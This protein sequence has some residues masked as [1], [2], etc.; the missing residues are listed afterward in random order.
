MK[1][2]GSLESGSRSIPGTST[3]RDSPALKTIKSSQSGWRTAT[4]RRAIDAVVSAGRPAGAFLR[5]YG[6]SIWPHAR[7]VFAAVSEEWA[8]EIPPEGD[9]V[10]ATNPQYRLTAEG[11]LRLLPD[12]RQV[13]LIAGSTD[14][15]RRWLQAARADL[16][17]LDRRLAVHELA[18]LTWD[19]VLERV[20]T[21]P[22]DSVA[23][24]VAFFA[25]ATG[26]TFV[27]RD[28]YVDLAAAANRPMFAT[29]STFAGAGL[30]GGL[31]IDYRLVG[32]RAA[33]AAA[34]ELTGR[35]RLASNVVEA[36]ESRWMF[37]GRQLARWGIRESRL[38]A[39]SEVLFREPSFFQRNKNLALGILAVVALQA[40]IIGMLLIERRVRRRTEAQNHAVLTSMS[41][42]LAVIDRHGHVV[43]SNDG[44]ARAAAAAENPFVGAGRGQRWLHAGGAPPA[45]R[46]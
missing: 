22:A 17:T 4:G 1:R 13:F 14:S 38:P 37:D 30:V 3:W 10:I 35:P 7:R 29:S 6:S 25:D 44:W 36:A 34:A 24:A 31:V 33:R 43:S 15:D 5:E 12:I 28:A 2:G 16:S 45:G 18:G 40:A 27:S 39:G 26:R 11:A 8:R 42:D 9:T 20:G 32:R 46:S 19:D 23:M 41:A 21:L